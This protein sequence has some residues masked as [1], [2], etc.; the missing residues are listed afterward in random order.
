MLKFELLRHDD[1]DRTA[2]DLCIAVLNKSLEVFAYGDYL[3]SWA[4]HKGSDV[5]GFLIEKDLPAV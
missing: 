2:D 4:V 5:K 1:V 3:Q